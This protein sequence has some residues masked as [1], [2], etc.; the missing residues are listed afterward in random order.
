MKKSDLILIENMILKDTV[1]I[2]E[3]GLPLTDTTQSNK[4]RAWFIKNYPTKASELNL[5]P[6]GP[7]DNATI[8]QA[9]NY[10][11]SDLDTT[12][13]GQEFS[14]LNSS[15]GGLDDGILGFGITG[16]DILYAVAVLAGLYVGGRL[17]A[18]KL[19]QVG[20]VTKTL[21]D[22]SKT[23]GG[24]GRLLKFLKSD[25][26]LDKLERDINNTLEL[27]EKE[28]NLIKTAIK[29]PNTRIALRKL[30]SKEAAQKLRR[31]EMTAEEFIQETGINPKGKTA[32]EARRIVAMQK[33]YGP[34][35]KQAY[36]KQ[37]QASLKFNMPS[38][39]W[40]AV[41]TNTSIKFAEDGN[42][43]LFKGNASE[44]LNDAIAKSIKNATKTNQSLAN[45]SFL[46][47]T[48]LTNTVTDRLNSKLKSGNARMSKNYLSLNEYPSFEQYTADLRA[49]GVTDQIDMTR[50]ITGQTLWRLAK[51]K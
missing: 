33:K 42:W 29:N 2:T 27:S 44:K 1:I 21:K 49:A 17:I 28:K 23:K 3:Q 50:Y 8:T 9:W 36:E 48:N 24:L 34:N 25:R 14:N 26:D 5:D 46:Q 10:R 18:K 19:R 12:T 20:R 31:G 40:S 30:I 47:R 16:W 7:K 38:R 15:A 35:W 4:F 37:K 13:A 22:F 41:P 11:P 51:G 39:Q 45:Q 43:Y 32:R 6:T